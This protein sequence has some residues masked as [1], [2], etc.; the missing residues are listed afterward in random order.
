MTQDNEIILISLASMIGL[1]ALVVAIMWGQR[2]NQQKKTWPTVEATV[3]SAET[4]LVNMGGRSKVSL[5]CCAFSYVIDGEY[6][7]GRFGVTEDGPFKE[8][9]DQKLTI[10][11]DPKRPSSFYIPANVINGCQVLTIPE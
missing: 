7:S 9:I 11:Y 1:F 2:R 6:Y 8:L 3:Q 4:E 5:P 10:H